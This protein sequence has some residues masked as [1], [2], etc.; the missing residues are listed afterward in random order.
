MHDSMIGQTISHY[1]IVEKLGGGGMGVVYKAEDITLHRFV[2]LKFLPDDVAKDPQALARFQREAQAASAL[3][4]PN[5]CTV[6][7]IGQQDGQ[8]FLVMEFLDGVTLKHRIA[9]KP[10]ETDV[11]LGLAIE[12][13]DALDAAHSKGIVHRDIKPAN[14]FV[15]ERGHAKIL[16]FGLAKVNASV[17][18]SI[19]NP[20]ANTQTLTIEQQ[21]TSP[22]AT[23]GTVAYMSPEQARAKALD[24]R[25]DL[26]SF[27]AVL[28]EMATGALPFRGESSAVIFKAIL[29]GTPTSAVRLNPDLPPK[30]EDIINKALEKDRNL[31]YQGAA[32]MRT[33]L[34]RLKRDTETRPAGA[35][36][37]LAGSLGDPQQTPRQT[38][39]GPT[40]VSGLHN[41]RPRQWRTGLA[42]AAG[43]AVVAIAILTF[44][45]TV[46]PPPKVSGYVQVTNDGSAKLWGE[47]PFALVT[48][49]SRV[50]FVDS[51]WVSPVLTQVST[52]G[53][54]TSA[55][56]TPFPVSRIG[57]IS[58]DRSALLIPAYTARE[59]GEPQGETPLWV[60]PLPA[61]TP[62]RL[63]GLIGHDGT[64]FPDGQRIVFAN[65]ND[66]YVARTDGTESKKFVTVPGFPRWLR[67]SP[68]GS[69]LRISVAT[70]RGTESESLWEVQAD[71]T[72][73]HPLLP[74]WNKPSQ[75]CCGSW[76]P[77][78]KYFIFQSTR[79]AKAQLWAIPEKGGLFRRARW[80]PLE[81][82]TGPL[83][84][85]M[86]IPSVD[87]KKLFA[88]GSQPRG[89]LGRFNQNT[90]QFEPYLSGISAE[91]VDFSRDGQWVTYTSYPEGSLWRSKADG[92]DRLRLTFPPTQAFLPRWSPDQKQIVFMATLPGKPLKNY[93]VSADGGT[94]QQLLPEE[95]NGEFDP[96]WSPDGTSLVFW[97]TPRA[98]NWSSG[99]VNILDLRTHRVSVVPGSEGL[100]SPRWSPDG[101]YIAASS[102]G[103]QP[104]ML[105]D[106]KTQKWAELAGI[107]VAYPNWSRDGNYIYFHSFGSDTALY[108]VRVSDHK[109]EKIV[110]LKGIRLTIGTFGAWSGLAPD[111]SPLILRDVGSQEIY[112]LDL[113][114]P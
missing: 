94:P 98:G 60:L 56:A 46:L 96:T 80:E 7:E 6:H 34:L 99:T 24:A 19:H 103:G 1:R 110:S 82:T 63:G 112:A 8:T 3:N 38:D 101:R 76:T 18:S 33:D 61:G 64:W 49:G 16:D 35:V 15:T 57:D 109:L 29:D 36:G 45:L 113:Q 20:S 75:E 79:N 10:M 59:R 26:F 23:L 9:G 108:R 86:P 47:S 90:Q 67:W 58:P 13:A 27:G 4:H 97:S 102:G 62:H 107:T 31:R 51:P 72:H 91:G 69:R 42:V 32:E 83:S 87:G 48:D 22:G 105:F 28:Y 30:L 93:L 37:A 43:I 11:L 55:I 68:D 85:S 106:F 44:R 2:A 17:S 73:L 66:L 71:G 14:I 88:I 89:E 84:Y 41:P 25:T 12:I 74:D 21:L 65:G 52:L 111:D 40:P 53:G 5:I 81:L 95:Q 104:L 39:P 92:S 78:G 54:E 50:Y 70:V 100:W 77:D 114:L